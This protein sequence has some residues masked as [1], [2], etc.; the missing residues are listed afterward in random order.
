MSENPLKQFFRRPAVYIRLP[1]NGDGY[2]EGSIEMTESG[3]LPVFPMTA[4]D[5]ITSRTPDALYNGTAVVDLIK[6][7]VPNIKDPWKMPSIDLDPILVAIRTATHGNTMEIETHCPSCDEEAK[8]DVN[9]PGILSSFKPGNYSEMLNIDNVLYVKF[10]PLTYTEVNEASMLQL[11]IQKVLVRLPDIQDEA[12]RDSEGKKFLDKMNEQY[13]KLLC[14][15]IQF[16]KADNN[17]VFE[18]DYIM[19][20]LKNCD[21]RTYDKIRDYSLDLRASAE[22]KPLKMK[23]IHCQHEYEQPLAINVSSFFV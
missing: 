17:I 22:S 9:L 10:R 18:R 11:E 12:I 19:D 5:E 2:P 23:C 14:D 15:T 21:K 4:V 1:S 8:Y 3:E 13:M 7:C 20:F 16:V 6:S